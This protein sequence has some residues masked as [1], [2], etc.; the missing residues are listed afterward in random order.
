MTT[1][2][3]WMIATIALMLVFSAYFSASE[4]ALL[5]L[6][7]ARLKNLAS[8]GDKKAALALK[9]A[10][11]YDEVISTILIGNNIVNIVAASL[12]SFLFTNWMGTAGVSVSTAVLT[13]LVLIFG[14]ISPK[15]LGKEH[16]DSFSQFSAPILRVL[17]VVLK[18]ANWLFLQWRKLLS[19]IFVSKDEGGMTGEELMT[20]V[21][22]AE[23]E[24]GIDS[25]EGQLI[26]AAIEF[27]D[28][29]AADILTPRVD[30]TAVDMDDPLEDVREIFRSH[31][32]SRLPVY[33]E[34][35]D[36]I[37]G[38]IH[39]KDFFRA[40]DEPGTTIA[41]L[42]E[43]VIYA[44]PSM[45]I[46]N[47]LQLLQRSKTHMAVVVDEF[48][49]T[50]GIITMED[51]LENL[52]GEIWD[53]HDEVIEDFQRQEDGSYIIAC[54][55]NLEE[56]FRLFSMDRDYDAT[57]VSGWV[58]QE[59]E[60]IPVPGDTFDYENLHVLIRRTDARRVLEIQVWAKPLPQED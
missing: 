57:T 21:E 19:K 36:S 6:N 46:S 8:A 7:H 48:G 26:R 12:G 14:E 42:I 47:L 38:V 23:S 13:V 35:V 39:E 27:D 16:A 41:S 29:D 50:E 40:Y 18:P 31:G 51:I 5:S 2:D 17:I 34:T 9:M 22:E 1:S 45:K 55:A 33:K 15:V 59:M 37:V 49:G 32:F 10:D 58:I 43:P 30:I 60:R 11:N 54:T 56:M 44:T 3:L 24:G 53:E 28:L 20:L 52:V 4:T 25:H